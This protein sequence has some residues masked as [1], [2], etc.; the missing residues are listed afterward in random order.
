[1]LIVFSDAESRVEV[2]RRRTD[3]T[4]GG[5][6][7]PVVPGSDGHANQIFHYLLGINGIRVLFQCRIADLI[8]SAATCIKVYT[9]GG[10]GVGVEVESAAGVCHPLVSI[11]ACDVGIG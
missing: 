6:L 10:T 11:I 7:G 3:M 1:V 8:P 9:A 5:I 2:L 4:N